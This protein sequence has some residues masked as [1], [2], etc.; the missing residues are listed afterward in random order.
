[1]FK[2]KNLLALLLALTMVIGLLSACGAETPQPT[3]SG[4]EPVSGNET[5]TEE[6]FFDDWPLTIKVWVCNTGNGYEYLQSCASKFNSMQ[7]KYIVDLSYAGSYQ[8]VLLKM[9]TSSAGSRPDIFAADTESMYVI[10]AQEDI[11]VPIQ[12]YIDA[13]NYDMSSMLSNLQS[14]YTQNGQWQAMPLGNTVTG[15]F[16]NADMLKAA[17]IDPRTD[18]GSYEEMVEACRILKSKGCSTPFYLHTSSAFYTFPMTAQGIHYVDN[19]NGKDGTPTRTLIGDEGT[20]AYNAT[21]SFFDTIMTMS[22]E[23][24][25][26]PFGTTV[27]DGR[28]AF[29]NGE[30]AFFTEFI[31]SFNTINTA[32]GGAF[33][34]G[35]HEC[36]TID[37][38][39][40][41]YGQCTGGGCL[42]LGNNGDKWKEQGAWEFMKFLMSD[43][44]TAGFA[45]A[46]GYLPT[47]TSGYESASYQSFV[48][49]D[50]P[51]AKYSLEA[52]QATGESCYNAWLPMFS[53]FH[54]LCREFYT[55]AYN[56]S[57]SPEDLTKS[58]A[59]AFDEV[60][61][62]YHL[63]NG[64]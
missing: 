16:Y 44:N 42:F 30:M 35:F 14:T 36:P 18:L 49:S 31:S 6:D 2:L 61:E 34:V 50:F 12:K 48:A 59:R 46:S 53:D 23:G 13:D 51:S 25:M 21:V 19:N 58:F 20:D 45:Q 28:A 1:M 33:E 26:M 3:E 41:N 24:L 8:D 43:E 7:D 10:L 52:Q 11:F 9:R 47:T 56:R 27:A 62:L 63:S 15:F 29:A 39:V 60:I 22:E 32:V 55:K 40:T 54:A 64:G 37:A 17:G 38:G 57:S 4:K 5:P